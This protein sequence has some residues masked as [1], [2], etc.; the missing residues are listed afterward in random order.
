MTDAIS[1]MVKARHSGSGFFMQAWGAIIAKLIPHVPP[2]YR[3]GIGSSIGR[4]TNP[5]LGAVTP[6]IVG[7]P[8]PFC[9]IE[10]RIG[11]SG[12]NM[13]LDAE[14]NQAMHRI[15]GPILQQKIDQE[16]FKKKAE[17]EKQGWIERAP[18][19]KALGIDV[20]F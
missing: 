3:R 6:A 12:K 15:L 7:T 1:R 14:K 8:N 9:I 5:D 19:L 4:R 20:S 10:L 13:T 18:K 16:F 2:S 11:M 17:A